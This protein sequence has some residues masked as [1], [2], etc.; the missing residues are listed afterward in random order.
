M[1]L[2]MIPFLASVTLYQRKILNFRSN[3]L[4]TI[5]W[6]YDGSERLKRY[7]GILGSYYESS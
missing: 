2:E 3:I 1:H 7:N 4:K 6:L 5:R